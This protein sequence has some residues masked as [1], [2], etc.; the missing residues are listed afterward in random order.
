VPPTFSAAKVAGRR[1]YDMARQGDEVQL[2]ARRVH[3]YGIDI[4]AYEYPRLELGVRCGKGAYIR[5]LARGLGGRVR[6]G[7]YVEVLR[8]TRVGPF[9]ASDALSLDTDAGRARSRLLPVVAAVADLAHV[10]LP[11]AAVARLRQGQTVPVPPDAF[12]QGHGEADA[13]VA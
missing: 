6:C 3:V 1:A 2:S 5:A 13:E 12:P 8:R 7:A 10:T 11:A 9:D 4:P